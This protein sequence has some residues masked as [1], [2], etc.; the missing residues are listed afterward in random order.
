MSNS[1]LGRLATSGYRERPVLL[2]SDVGAVGRG[3]DPIGQFY[4]RESLTLKHTLA[5]LQSTLKSASL[6]A[7][8]QSAMDLLL[9]PS[10]SLARRKAKPIAASDGLGRER[11]AAYSDDSVPGDMQPEPSRPSLQIAD[12]FL[13]VGAATVTPGSPPSTSE[14][15]PR[16]TSCRDVP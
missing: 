2:P 14:R 3:P 12:G 4:R 15:E 11:P 10:P 1:F 8:S 13:T 7:T 16:G 6:Y 5:P 9:S